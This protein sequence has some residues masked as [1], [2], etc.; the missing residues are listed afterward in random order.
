MRSGLMPQGHLSVSGPADFNWKQSAKSFS[1][2]GDKVCFWMRATSCAQEG[3]LQPPEEP[4]GVIA[5]DTKHD[6]EMPLSL[7]CFCY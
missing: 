1:I 5:K 6:S 3:F 2:C 7:I 4:E